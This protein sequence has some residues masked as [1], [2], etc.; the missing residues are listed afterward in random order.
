[1]Q[2]RIEDWIKLILPDCKAE[3]IKEMDTDKVPAKKESRLDKLILIDAPEGKSIINI[4]PQGYLDY[5]L[6]ARMLRDGR[7]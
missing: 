1:M 6:P 5:K 4:E 7:M 2:S 3:W